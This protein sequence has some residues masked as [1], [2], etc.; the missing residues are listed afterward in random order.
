MPNFFC[1]AAL[2]S[3]SFQCCS[4]IFSRSVVANLAQGTLPCILRVEVWKSLKG[5][6]L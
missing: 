5:H 6:D 1:I 3:F 4:V 2:R